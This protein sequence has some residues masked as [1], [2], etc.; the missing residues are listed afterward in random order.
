MDRDNPRKPK[1]TS[2]KLSTIALF[3]PQIGQLIELNWDLL[4]RQDLILAKERPK[5]LT[6]A[7]SKKAL[8]MKGLPKPSAWDT[9]EKWTIEAFIEEYQTNWEAPGNLRDEVRVRLF[10]SF[11][12]E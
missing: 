4:G 5:V 9:K 10:G 2:K 1:Q 11:Q 3:T 12:T 8:Y 6:L 7:Q